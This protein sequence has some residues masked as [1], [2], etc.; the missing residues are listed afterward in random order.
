MYSI[1]GLILVSL[2]TSI[3]VSLGCAASGAGGR[4][5]EVTQS[6]DGCTPLVIDATPGEKLDLEVTNKTGSTY[7]VE[8]IDGTNLEEVLVPEGR[9]RSIGYNV[10]EAGG[11]GKVKCYVPGGVST[12]IEIH[13]GEGTGSAGLDD[14]AEGGGQTSEAET[15]PADASVAVSLTEYTVTPA[16][17]AVQA[18][19]IRFEA[20]NDSASMVHELA[21]LRVESDG[22]LENYGEIEDL[23]PGGSGT[24]T[25]D[26]TPGSYQLACLLIPGEAGSTT[27]HY[28]EGMWTEFT[29]E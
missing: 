11:V 25:I 18:G 4:R 14:G 22:S 28:Q 10:P 5:I 7:E 2:A 23:E 12:I 9:T 26:L 8:G 3:V 15:G 17:D 29:V 16:V 27:D 20:I 1:R 21:V 13:A 19:V 6:E 24:I